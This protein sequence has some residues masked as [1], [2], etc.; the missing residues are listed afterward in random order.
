MYKKKGN[1]KRKII[2]LFL[3]LV[4]SPTVFSA[5]FEIGT[6]PP[7]KKVHVFYRGYHF[8]RETD[9]ETDFKGRQGFSSRPISKREIVDVTEAVSNMK[10][11][12]RPWTT[13]EKTEFSPECSTPYKELIQLYTNSYTEFTRQLKNKDSRTRKIFRL[14]MIEVSENP[15]ISTTLFPHQAYRYGNGSKLY[16]R[17]EQR[18][19]P[20]YDQE[21]KP[22]NKI[23]GYMDVYIVPEK[24]YEALE[25]FN[26]VGNF[27]TRATKL[28]CHCRKDL[29]AEMEFIFPF[30]IGCRFH[31]ARVPIRVPDF[32]I[33]VL[34]LRK[35]HWLEKLKEAGT[36]EER[37]KVEARIIRR[38]EKRDSPEIAKRVIDQ[39]RKKGVDVVRSLVLDGVLLDNFTPSNAKQMRQE[40][41]ILEK[42]IARDYRSDG[43]VCL[44]VRKQSKSLAWAL[45]NFASRGDNVQ[46]DFSVSFKKFDPA[47]I[48][49]YL[50]NSNVTSVKFTGDGRDTESKAEFFNSYVNWAVKQGSHDSQEIL[51]R[52]FISVEEDS[53]KKLV[54]II[55][56]RQSPITIDIEGIHMHPA[57]RRLFNVKNASMD[58]DPVV[59]NSYKS[60]WAAL[61]TLGIDPFETDEE[62]EEAL[63]LYGLGEFDN[64]TR[65]TA[66][67]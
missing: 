49:V 63:E 25:I 3:T 1:L 4:F 33:S 45:R 64:N 52:E 24:E 19:F 39:L 38:L 43:V 55:E 61:R 67:Y 23:I 30:A 34:K 26:V 28:S 65:L 59:R 53:I 60:Y 12:N 14:G 7:S 62:E 5:A 31:F 16:G 6:K 32:R 35:K 40:I 46:I 58:D 51:D 22:T 66:W 56:K 42:K 41:D 15:F 9:P 57:I 27:A 8:L 21:G 37:H 54:A 2:L 50:E 47:L 20:D 13:E 44:E 10:K 48:G 18:R 36:V 29:T 11:L 17:K